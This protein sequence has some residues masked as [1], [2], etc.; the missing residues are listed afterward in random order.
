MG[1][2]ACCFTGHRILPLNILESVITRLNSEIDKLISQGVTVFYSGGAL[3]FD[4]IAASAI[5][6]KKEEGKNIKLI[7]ALPCKN[8]D[9]LW[10]MEQRVLYQNLLNEA[11]EVIYVCEEY[12]EDC[13]K[14]R[15]YYMVDHSDFGIFASQKQCW[16]V[17]RNFCFAKTVLDC[18]VEPSAQ[19]KTH[20]PRSS[21]SLLNHPHT[22]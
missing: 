15:N 7:F 5:I 14:K 17:R 22:S 19:S 13:M 1:E 2:T 16:T 6:C 20:H 3:G 11:D 4:Q 18:A 12:N 8:Q 10:T 9:K 21:G